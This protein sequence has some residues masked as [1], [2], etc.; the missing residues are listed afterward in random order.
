MFG[1]IG[2]PTVGIYFEDPH[3]PTPEEDAEA[4]RLTRMFPEATPDIRTPLWSEG[5]QWRKRSE[6]DS[7]Q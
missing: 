5:R 7:G 2:H 6:R 4:C 1:E 3:N